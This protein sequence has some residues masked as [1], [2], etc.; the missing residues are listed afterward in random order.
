MK[1]ASD[2]IAFLEASLDTRPEGFLSFSTSDEDLERLTIADLARRAKAIAARLQILAQ[3]GDRALLLFPPGLAFVEAFFGCLYA[4]VVAVPAH[5]PRRSRIAQTRPRLLGI[6]G[7]SGSRLVLTTVDEEKKIAPLL[8]EHLD[9]SV[10]WIATDAIETDASA[11]RR[12]GIEPDDLAFLQYTSGS[13]AAPKGVMVTHRNLLA[14]SELIRVAFRHRRGVT[15]GVT[16]LPPQHDMGLIGGILQPIYAQFDVMV[17]SPMQF[18]SRPIRWLQAITT[19]GASTSG[20]PNF[21]YQ[22][23]ADRI[24]PDEIDGLDLRTWDV[25]FC[26]AEP[27][28]ARTLAAFVE[29]FS[30]AGFRRSSFYPCYGLAESTLMVTGGEE[31]RGPIEIERGGRTFVGSGHIRPGHELIVVDTETGAPTRDGEVGEIWT[32]GPSVATGYF[33]DADRTR[34]TFQASLGGKAYLRTGDLGFIVDGELFV[35][36]RWKDVIV[37]RG[38][39]HHPNDIELSVEESCPGLRDGCS[40]AFSAEVADE[41]RLV[42]VFEVERRLAKGMEL[43]ATKSAFVAIRRA[44][45]RDHGIEVGAILL[46]EPGAVPKTPS[47]KVRRRA[48]RDLFVDNGYPVVARWPSSEPGEIDE[49]RK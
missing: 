15:R 41:E 16:W 14:N 21:A 20:A 46:V 26:G 49:P 29:R 5:P 3:K 6:A 2:W 19:F 11:W 8:S 23:C 40:A 44:I 36:G 24:G 18:L 1:P 47:G 38:A 10:S 12:P 43:E 13:T 48:A 22:L 34:E 45:A 27:I 25:A 28:R 7:I 30:P 17:M 35:S 42:V 9:P 39:K 4:G 33:A 37:L 32:R 31:G